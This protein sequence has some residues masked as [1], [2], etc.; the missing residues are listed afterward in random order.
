MN[1]NLVADTGIIDFIIDEEFMNTYTKPE[2]PKVKCEHCTYLTLQVI[3]GAMLK[4][5]TQKNQTNVKNLE[6]NVKHAE[7]LIQM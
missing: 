7:K 6:W 2:K 5:C 1:G 3:W 4:E